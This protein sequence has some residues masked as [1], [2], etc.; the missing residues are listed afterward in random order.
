MKWITHQTGA[1]A[2]GL[3]LQMPLLAVGAAFAGA[4]LPDV[5]DQSI[6]RMGRNKKQRQKIFN[7]IHR[8]N[9]HWFG[10]WLGLFI[11]GAAAPLSPVCKA[12]CAG[13]AMGAT[14]HVLL[15]MLTTQGV[16]LLPFTR[17]N[18]VS[19]SLCST[20]K[21]GEYVFLAAIVAVS[22]CFMGEDLAA[23]AMN[24]ASDWSRGPWLRN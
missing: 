15:D 19:L 12:L 10:W 17:K 4:I 8:G 1:V 23:A 16:P 18:R 14:S 20:G 9:S 21:M 2:A 5:L 6:S 24:I 13:L 7:R 3:A 11:V 22:A